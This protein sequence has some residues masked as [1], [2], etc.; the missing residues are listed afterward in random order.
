MTR[1]TVITDGNRE[2]RS[3]TQWHRTRRWK[4]RAE[5]QK[6]QNISEVGNR[7]LGLEDAA[8]RYSQRVCRVARIH[9]ETKVLHS[10]RGAKD[11]LPTSPTCATELYR[12]IARRTRPTPSRPNHSKPAV[13]APSGTCPGSDQKAAVQPCAFRSGASYIVASN[14]TP[15]SVTTRGVATPNGKGTPSTSEA[16]ASSGAPLGPVVTP[17]MSLRSCWPGSAPRSSTW[18]GGADGSPGTPK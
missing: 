16:K 9:P 7:A 11:P 18:V 15:V 6:A 8:R 2:R 13:A 3:T 5:R 12:C 1:Q 4:H 10:P 14:G 17:K